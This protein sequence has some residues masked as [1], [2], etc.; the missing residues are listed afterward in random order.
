ML[1]RGEEGSI[2]V[3]TRQAGPA[4]VA[5][6]VVSKL[7]RSPEEYLA[8]RV[9]HKINQYSRSAQRYRHW[10]LSMATMAAV[11][12]AIVPALINIPGVGD[13]PPTIISLV[14]AIVIAAESVFHTREHWRTYDQMSA[15]LREEEMRYSTGLS[16][17]DGG[18]VLSPEETFYR[19]VDRVEDAIAKERT[20]TI[21][22]RTSAA[23]GAQPAGNGAPPLHT[24][25]PDSPNPP[26]RAA[27]TQPP[28]RGGQPPVDP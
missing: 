10:Y 5:E 20:E 13:M 7:I 22:M 19:F 23:S 21:L 17:I 25:G 24:R 26:A 1:D 6:S 8:D 12:G 27:G 28:A 16:R 11:G 3:S 4:L 14:V 2:M 18:K 15:M 9:Q